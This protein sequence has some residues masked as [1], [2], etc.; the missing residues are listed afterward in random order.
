[1]NYE[2]NLTCIIRGQDWLMDLLRA[3]RELHLP[4]WYVA[5]GA[6][7]NTV[8]NVLH[9]YPSELHQNDV[10]VVYFDSHD[11]AGRKA[12]EYER[13]LRKAFPQRKWE[14]VNQAG[15]HLM[16]CT[17]HLGRPAAASSGEAI[18]YWTE[19]PTCVGVRLEINDSLTV[20]APHGLEDLMTM[21]V[22][23]SPKPYQDWDSYQQ[24]MSEKRWDLIWP[25]LV[26][27]SS[28]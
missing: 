25:H 24:R 18:A 1:M 20:C 8:W 9:G 26:I 10:D 21:K 12:E 5:A 6:I 17:R 15:A 13:R 11:L 19:T 22:R 3:T 4:D 23:P 28:T 2:E 27:G 7:R 14:V 16:E